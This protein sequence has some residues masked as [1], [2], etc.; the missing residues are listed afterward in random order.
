MPDCY[1]LWR[2]LQRSDAALGG[3]NDLSSRLFDDNDHHAKS[4]L[5]H[6]PKEVSRPASTTRGG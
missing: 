5:S 2:H 1:S 6:L 3:E 4:R